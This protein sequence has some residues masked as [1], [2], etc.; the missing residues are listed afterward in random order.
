LSR[1]QL[2]GVFQRLGGETQLETILRDFYQKLSQDVL[3]GFFFFG[4]DLEQIIQH[5]KD[6]LL[7]ASGAHPTYEGKMPV[8][9][10]RNLP[11]ILAGHFDRRIFILEQTLREHQLSPADITV[12][13]RFEKSFRAAM[14][15]ASRSKKD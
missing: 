4:K 5:Q 8:P 9:A 6:F 12:W 7:F 15:K 13:I 2:Q 10:H 14:L 1:R 11:P 3:V